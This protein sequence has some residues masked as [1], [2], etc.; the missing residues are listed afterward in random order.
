MQGEDGSGSEFY[1]NG[2][3]IYEDF[4][5][6]GPVRVG[7]FA[8]S[9]SSREAAGASYWGIMELS[10]N[11]WERVVSI[12]SGA[13]L[14][15]QGIHGDGALDVNGDADAGTW[16]GFNG[17]G[18]RGGNYNGSASYA[19]VSDR[20]RAAFA[21]NTRFGIFNCRAARTAP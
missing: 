21:S 16:P 3:L 6:G 12:G 13:G 1:E 4:N 17:A 2:N 10:G 8:R 5:P 9:G 14:S 19:R 20:H 7:I 11:L 18:C 15:F